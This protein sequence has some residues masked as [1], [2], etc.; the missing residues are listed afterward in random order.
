M[1]KSHFNFDFFLRNGWRFSGDAG[2]PG[3]VRGGEFEWSEIRVER[4]DEKAN[5]E[6]WD[7]GNRIGIHLWRKKALEKSLSGRKGGLGWRGTD[8]TTPQ[9]KRKCRQREGRGGEDESQAERKPG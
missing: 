8:R 4:S 1:T 9:A 6:D 3:W 2:L 5:G 7:G